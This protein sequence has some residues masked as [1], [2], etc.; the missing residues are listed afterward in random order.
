[1]K[2]KK[3]QPRRAADIPPDPNKP[4]R[5]TGLN[6]PLL[7]SPALSKFVGGETEMSRPEIVKKLWAH[8]KQH[9]LQDPADRRFILCD[10]ALRALFNVDRVNSFAMN[11][12]LTVHVSNK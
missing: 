12:D 1:K 10:D 7:L 2:K 6:K 4:K 5:K 3:R 8:I 11:K 9:D